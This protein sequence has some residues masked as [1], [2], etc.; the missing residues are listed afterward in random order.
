MPEIKNNFLKGKMNKDLDDRL[1][2]PGEYR[3]AQNIEVLKTDGANVG[4]LQNA[5]GNSLA[6]TALNLS[7][8]IDVI[9]TYFDEKNKRIYWFL[10]DNNDLYENDWYINSALNQNRFHAIYYYDA[11]PSSNTYKTA[12][13]IVGGSFLKFS[14]KYKITGIAM[15]DDLLFWTDNKNQPRRINVVKA[16]SNPSFYDNELKISLAKYAPYIA[17]I[18]MTDT[19]IAGTSTMTNDTNIDNDYIEEEFV[20]F[21][22]RFKFNDNEYSVLAPFSQIAFKHSYKSGSEYGE[23]DEAAE[24]RA[25]E[26]T[27]LDGMINNTN[28]VIIG[29]ELPSIN[30]NADFEIKEIEFIIKE[31]DSIVARVLETKTLTDANISSAF[32]NYTYKS[33]TPQNALPEDQ[34]TRVFDNVPTKAKAL[35]IVGNRLVFGNYSQNI[36]IP[37]LDYNVSYGA[38][39]TQAFTGDAI[40]TEFTLTIKSPVTPDQNLIP[41]NT[42]QFN[43]YIN[44]VLLASTEYGYDGTTGVITFNTAPANGAVITVVLANHEYPDSSLKQRRTYQVG[45]LLAD[46]F[47]RQSPVLLPTT[48]SDSIITVPARGT[49]AEFNSWIGD[50]LKITFNAQ[51][52]KLIPDDNVYSNELSSGI[53]A[54]YNP[55]GWYSYKI[56]VKQLEQDYYN[57][58]T[59]GATVVDNNSYITLFGDN[60]NK[61][62]RLLETIG[63]TAI[64][65]SDVLLYPKIINTAF[66]TTT[67]S[68]TGT[69]SAA[70]G[71]TTTTTSAMI[72]SCNQ[73]QIFNRDTNSARTFTYIPCNSTIASAGDLVSSAVSVSLAAGKKQKIWSLT[74]PELNANAD[75]GFLEIT[76]LTFNKVQDA[77]AATGYSEIEFTDPS[78]GQI[79]KTIE[80]N[81]VKLAQSL[82]D[83]DEIPILGIAKLS[84]F[85]SITID[86]IQ[87]FTR[88]SQVYDDAGGPF[89]QS[90]NNHLIAQLPPYDITSNRSDALGVRMLFTDDTA[91]DNTVKPDLS[92]TSYIKRGKYIDLAIF[93]TLPV[94]STI[95]IFYETSTSGKINELNALE[96]GEFTSANVTISDFAVAQDGEI[97]APLINAGSLQSVE[98]VNAVPN[99]G[100]DTN[101]T[102]F[103]VST[104][105]NRIAKLTI[106]APNGY[107]NAGTNIIIST[108]VVQT[109]TPGLNTTVPLFSDLSLVSTIATSGSDASLEVSA[110]ISNNGNAVVTARGFRIGTTNI[111]G[112]ADV[113]T[114]LSGGIGT[115]TA[116]KTDATINTLYYIWAWATNSQGTNV[117]GPIEITTPELGEFTVAEWTGSISVASNGSVT[118]V[119]GNSPEVLYAGTVSPNPSSTDTVQVT[120]GRADGDAAT[121]GNNNNTIRIQVPTSGYSNSGANVYLYTAVR[122]VT[123]PASTGGTYTIAQH[124]VPSGFSVSPTGV[125]TQGT[126]QQGTLNSVSLNGSPLTDGQSTNIS[127][128]N[129]ATLRTLTLNITPGGSFTNPLAADFTFNIVQPSREVAST[130]IPSQSTIINSTQT[131][132]LRNYYSNTSGKFFEITS[133][134]A[135]GS[136][137]SASIVNNYQLQLIGQGACSDVTG[138]TSAGSIV[139]KASNE[140]AVTDG[141]VAGSTAAVSPTEA[142]TDSFSETVNLSVTACAS[143]TAS[144]T[145]SF[146]SGGSNLAS[147]VSLSSASS[148][149]YTYNT[150]DI[151]SS[152]TNQ[153]QF[154]FTHASINL[155]SGMVS[156][157]SN[158]G[159][160]SYVVTENGDNSITIGFSGTNPNQSANNNI[161]YSFDITITT[162]VNYTSAVGFTMTNAGYTASSSVI[163]ASGAANTN[164]V[165][166]NTS[167]I[168]ASNSGTFTSDPVIYYQGDNPTATN[169]I[170]LT[171]HSSGNPFTLTASR[172]NNNTEIAISGT[173]NIL[174]GDTSGYA[175]VVLVPNTGVTNTVTGMTVHGVN[176]QSGGTGYHYSVN[177]NVANT[178][179][180]FTVSGTGNIGVAVSNA[181]VSGSVV[182]L[183][184]TSGYG[185]F[186]GTCTIGTGANSGTFTLT[187]TPT[188]GT[189]YSITVNVQRITLGG[190]TGIRGYN[191]SGP[192]SVGSVQADGYPAICDIAVGTNQI[193]SPS[194]NYNVGD[195]FYTTTEAAYTNGA[196][197]GVVFA[198]G[199]N[200]YRTQRIYFPSV[201]Y[202]PLGSQTFYVQLDNNG[203][204][205]TPGQISCGLNH[206]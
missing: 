189:P 117:E 151:G 140:K 141:S 82:V 135:T 104:D 19:G 31:S 20:R 73:Y 179:I 177:R 79:I 23:F 12:K 25:Y 118:T 187:A 35:D 144:L 156:S 150:S 159:G 16:I 6:H 180:P 46:I 1:L 127:V 197:Q 149:T 120:L 4:V 43:V 29:V 91:T 68:T 169:Y 105:T 199:N 62:P 202:I 89:Y 154:T 21:S 205:L 190:T 40:E 67:T 10:T 85:N 165:S 186:S 88:S 132:D 194:S 152:F 27:E 130:G 112:D 66:Y 41:N 188:G 64:A 128:V 99:A 18:L 163:S 70:T 90:Q 74:F 76:Q 78:S 56:V 8:D 171:S 54:T 57:I 166:M 129:S 48:V 81:S 155:T 36:E 59:P 198:G 47:G 182:N 32:Y 204:I 125:F 51:N 80:F 192:H 44:D 39:G 95:D 3:D 196:Q 178:T 172:Q 53:Y 24:I 168:T 173:A 34:I 38:K 94:E 110:T 96:T 134:S 191:Y 161:N 137:I 102:Y 148:K 201:A 184:T 115:Y 153:M 185:N 160:F 158:T 86:T 87:E 164:N 17:P 121:Y 14:K 83:I 195:T 157:V 175:N 123:Q 174:S 136:L 106:T 26:S 111:Y 37:T 75:V 206:P 61:V 93:E 170:Q 50:N 139:I 77:N 131:I 133:N 63:E 101:F 181:S 84:D 203:Q 65:K 49:A 124:A 167:T 138:T 45:V 107:T 5:A 69:R 113:I 183:N 22:Y 114:D 193:Y 97:T 58:Y 72:Y 200:Y 146:N 103:A 15:I 30:P 13:E 52:G 42:N 147:G 143:P 145:M 109:A 162:S 9:G 100:A 28:K 60:I 116:T 7:T 33:D 122:T 71:G 176:V 119:V 126:I 55:Y 11:D 2:P 92:I 108:T 98:Y 142:G